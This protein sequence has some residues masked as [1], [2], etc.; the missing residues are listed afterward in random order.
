MGKTSMLRRLALAVKADPDL[1][2]KLIPLSFRE[3]QYNVHSSQVF[4]INCLDALGDWFDSVKQPEKAELLDKDVSHLQNSGGDA[5]A[6][7]EQW[8]AREGRRPLLLLDNIDLIFSGLKKEAG[9]LAKFFPA[10]GGAIIVG[11]SATSVDVICEESGELNSSFHI[12]KL[13]RLSKNELISCLRSLALARG[14]D[15]ER[16]L[17]ILVNESARIET[18]HDLTGG[19]P[20][21]LTMLYMLL[22]TDTAGDVFGDLERLLDQATVLYKA[23]VEDLSAQ[24]RVVLDAVA[25]AWDPALAS[26]IAIAT[27]LEVTLVSSQLDRLLKE[28]I[29]EKVS[30]SKSS[31]AAFQVSERF[32]N[33]W[34]LM[35]H[36]ARRQRS[37]LRWLTLFLKSFYSHEQLVERAKSL[38]SSNG[39][40]GVDL[41]VETGQYLLALSDAIND[42]GWRSVLTNQAREEFERYAESRGRKLEEIINTD[43]VPLPSNAEDWVSYGNL[44]RQHLKRAKEAEAAFIRATELEPKNWSAWF[45]L[46]A[47]RFGDLA[48]P[49]GAVVALKEAIKKNRRHLP[50]VYMLAGALSATGEISASK[51]AYRECLR[52][53]PGFYLAAISLGDIYSEEGDLEQAAMQYQRAAKLAPKSATDALHAS[54]YFAAY[55]LEDFDRAIR[56]YKRLL[57]I[58]NADITALTNFELLRAITATDVA[59]MTIDENLLAKHSDAGKAIMLALVAIAR[60]DSARAISY[61]ATIFGDDSDQVFQTYK[62]FVLLLFRFAYKKGWADIVLRILDETGAGDKNWPLKVGY[63]AFAYGPERLLDVNPEVRTAASKILRLLSAPNSYRAHVPTTV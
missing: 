10:L 41:G 44:L 49:V 38:V 22:E 32:F 54:A 45:N 6:L 33:I 37:R 40:L 1:S 4:W 62:G 15:G 35:R 3:E 53:N 58:D 48:N 21:T 27:R 50:S 25:L 23:R 47:T 59:G 29:I 7:F 51:A 57:D 30:V 60:E 39:D 2:R 52:L 20:R 14:V 63:D 42:K 11:G 9:S 19:N 43:D 56:L 46:G 24:A 18:M 5:F 12:K 36:G 17:Q 31:K 8:M 26:E 28:G 61:M 16:V 55:M 13:D 34:Y